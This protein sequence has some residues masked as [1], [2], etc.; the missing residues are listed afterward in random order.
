MIIAMNETEQQDLAFLN[1]HARRMI[2]VLAYQK[3]DK[4]NAAEV[5][6]WKNR[7]VLLGA[8]DSAQQLGKEPM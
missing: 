2:P 7:L 3:I 8:V 5:R 6:E 1:R 4:T